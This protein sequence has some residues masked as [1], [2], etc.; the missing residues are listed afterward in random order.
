M[1]LPKV[2]IV[3]DY[4]RESVAVFVDGK[5]VYGDDPYQVRILDLLKGVLDA[6]NIDIDY[7]EQF[8]YGRPYEFFEEQDGE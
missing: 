2:T 5:H 1:G 3:E 6:I 8:T 7:E 4:D